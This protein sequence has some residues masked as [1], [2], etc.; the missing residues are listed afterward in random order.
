M[1]CAGSGIAPFRGFWQERIIEKS[2]LK[3][4][5]VGLNGKKWGEMVLYFG[6]RNS[7]H[8]QLYK[9]ELEPLI[10]GGLISSYNVAF[11]REPE[12]EKVCI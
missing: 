6:C 5:P 8:D 4:S 2:N 12:K 3:I 1:V 7:K 11:S 10:K 9:N